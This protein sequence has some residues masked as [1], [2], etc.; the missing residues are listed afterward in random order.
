MLELLDVA[1]GF[2]T[3]M[4]AVSLIIMSLTQAIS[5]VLALRGARL[6]KGLWHLIEHTAPSLKAHAK[7]LSRDIVSH[8]LV[9]DAA[10]VFPGPW[11][12]ASLIKKEELMPVLDAVL[13]GRG[14]K[15]EDVTPQEREAIEEWFDAF[16]TRVSQWFAMNTRWITVALALVLSFT[17]HFDA[18]QVLK[19][20]TEDKETRA[21]V[22]AMSASLLDQTPESVGSVEARYSEALKELFGSNVAQFQDGTSASALPKITK[23]TE[24]SDWI[25]THVKVSGDKDALVSQ[26]ND[27]VDKKL[28]EAIDQS[29]DRAKT[30]QGTLTSAGI[31]LPPK[32]HTRED[33][34]AVESPHF[35]GMLASVL[36]L[37]LGAP[38]WFNL[39]KNMTS[40][41]SA[42]ALKKPEGGNGEVPTEGVFAGVPR[43]AQTLPALP[44]QPPTAKQ[45]DPKR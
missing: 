38:F 30:L 32:G 39:L 36:F 13:K 12:W 4:L 11:R 22:L 45:P 5:S 17:M 19:Q 27:S 44:A 42:V 9:S 40:L 43:P 3:V 14:L 37:S 8:P 26:Y 34:L 28:T 18:V 7:E 31:A 35:W 25:G 1:I 16:M 15:P 21:K 41:K 6:R 29:I 20:L 2:A 33:W 24:A 10:T 23:R